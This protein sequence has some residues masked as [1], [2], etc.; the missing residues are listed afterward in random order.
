MDHTVSL[1]RS[2]YLKIKDDI[3]DQH[4]SE[5]T[6]LPTEQQLAVRFGVN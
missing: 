2:I 3:K 6:K 1:W 4:Y 5:G